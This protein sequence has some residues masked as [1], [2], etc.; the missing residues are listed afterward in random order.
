MSALLTS[1]RYANLVAS[2][3]QLAQLV[4]EETGK[5]S[6]MRV[7]DVVPNLDLFTWWLP[8]LQLSPRRSK[9]SVLRYPAKEG[10]W[11][12]KRRASSASYPVELPGRLASAGVPAL[13]AGNALLFKPSEVTPKT[14]ALIASLFSEV[15]PGGLVALV[16]EAQRLGA[17]LSTSP[18]MWSLLVGTAG[19]QLAAGC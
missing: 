8:R 12:M 15:L 11:S 3:E 1:S 7:A 19:R 13:L 18:I 5:S 17:P 6:W 9:L 14:G 10:S 2:A 4:S 16:Q